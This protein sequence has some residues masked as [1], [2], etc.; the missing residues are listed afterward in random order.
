M[1]SGLFAVI[2]SDG[3]AAGTFRTGLLGTSVPA[4]V[5]HTRGMAAGSWALTGQ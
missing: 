5:V 4:C 2:V 1:D 3:Q